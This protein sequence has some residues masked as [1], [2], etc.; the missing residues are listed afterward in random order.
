MGI[1]ENPLKDPDW[2]MVFLTLL[3]LIVGARTLFV[4]YRQFEEM[5]RQTGILDAQAKQAAADSIEAAKRVEQQLEIAQQQARAAQDGVRVLQEQM[6]QTQKTLYLE[7]SPWLAGVKVGVEEDGGG[8]ERLSVI[9]V[10][11]GKTPAYNTR[12]RIQFR[13]LPSDSP[14]PTFVFKES[15]A[16]GFVDFVPGLPNSIPLNGSIPSHVVASFKSGATHAFIGLQLWYKDYWG[17]HSSKFCQYFDTRSQQWVA[18]K[19]DHCED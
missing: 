5:Q 12:A 13:T 8:A 18:R 14:P 9:V 17:K 2:Y 4:F 7:E 11:A 3:L 16:K 10:N 19:P 1:R 15:E 6:R